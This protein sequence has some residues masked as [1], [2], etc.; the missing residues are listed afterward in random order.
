MGEPMREADP[1]KSGPS[2]ALFLD[3]DGTLVE[4]AERP[5]AVVVHPGMLPVLE[6]LQER[7]GGALAVISGRPIAFLDERLAP[8]RFDAAGLHGLEHRIG[9]K[10]SPCRPEDYPDLRRE[11]ERLQNVV[12]SHSGMIVEDK[13]CSVALHWRMAPGEADFA[14]ELARSTAAT[15][16]EDYRLQFGKAVAEILPAASGKGRIIQSFLSEMP[17]RGRTPVFVGDDLT[18]EHGFDAV[19]QAGGISVR[20]GPGPS[21]A[22]ARLDTPSDLHRCLERWA[23]GGCMPFAGSDEGF[24]GDRS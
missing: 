1:D 10:L 13:G 7:L 9:G 14:Q 3:F 6:G 11:V 16:G 23:G 20:I 21:I 17:Y 8:C 5:D 12:A 19:N 2:W 15:L 18:D 24:T 22:K 4:I